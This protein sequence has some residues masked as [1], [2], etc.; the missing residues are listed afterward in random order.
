MAEKYLEHCSVS[1]KSSKWSYIEQIL[2]LNN[3]PVVVT[4][5]EVVEY[6]SSIDGII[7]ASS[8]NVEFSGDSRNLWVEEQKLSISAFKLYLCEASIQPIIEFLNDLLSEL[9][10]VREIG[11]KKQGEQ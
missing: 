6:G 1:L 3:D 8:N 4:T 7:E 5:I 2:R 11:L 10:V 9:D